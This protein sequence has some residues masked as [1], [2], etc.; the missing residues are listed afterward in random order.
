MPN[1]V[2]LTPL[3][4]G[5]KGQ[6]VKIWPLPVHSST[7]AAIELTVLEPKGCDRA[8]ASSVVIFALP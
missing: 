8:H 3:K 1:I 2:Y 6:K 4:R 7:L 5:E